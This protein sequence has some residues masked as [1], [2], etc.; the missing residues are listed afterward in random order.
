M[1]PR[2][3]PTVEPTKQGLMDAQSAPARLGLGLGKQKRHR[4]RGWDF[5]TKDHGWQWQWGL[6]L[7]C[8]AV[9]SGLR[10]GIPTMNSAISASACLGVHW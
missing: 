3:V 6:K 9:S 1:L 2:L 10:L 4:T 5:G 7:L 8:E